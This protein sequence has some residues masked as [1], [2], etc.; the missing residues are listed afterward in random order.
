MAPDPTT[1]AIEAA[2]AEREKLRAEIMTLER[3]VQRVHERGYDQAVREI[4]NHFA[5]ASRP[6]VAAEIDKIFGKGRTMPIG[7]TPHE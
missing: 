1:A 7:L 2:N 4:R 5:N 6:E 3:A